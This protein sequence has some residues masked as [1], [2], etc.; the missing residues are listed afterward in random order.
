MKSAFKYNL[1]VHLPSNIPTVYIKQPQFILKRF[2]R[3]IFTNKVDNHPRWNATHMPFTSPPINHNTNQ[4]LLSHFPIIPTCK[5]THPRTIKQDPHQDDNLTIQH[6]P[7]RWRKPGQAR[8][9]NI[10]QVD[11]VITKYRS[12]LL[13]QEVYVCFKM[14]DVVARDGP[15]SMFERACYKFFLSSHLI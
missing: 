4:T 15:T 14:W 8:W 7:P 10:G 3:D 13:P 5:S 11:Y 1:Q 6:R 12:H 2:S 9:L